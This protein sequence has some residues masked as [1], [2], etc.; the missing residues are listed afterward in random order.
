MT[1]PSKAR[2]RPLSVLAL[3]LALG[4]SAGCAAPA[5]RPEATVA[6]GSLTPIAAAQAALQ[7]SD[8][9]SAQTALAASLRDDLP[10]G[11]LQFLYALTYDQ[12][13]K[14]GSSAQLDMAQVG[15]ENAVRFT[16]QNYWARLMMGYLKLERGEFDAAQDHFAVAAL[17]QPQRWEAFY[18]LGVAS[19]HRGDLPMLQLAANRSLALAAEQ[20][21]AQRLAAFSL[22]MQGDDRARHLADNA[23]QKVS[24]VSGNSED[25]VF[26]RK[27]VDELLIGAQLRGQGQSQNLQI[28]IAP[29]PVGR[30]S[31]EFYTPDRKAAFTDN[32]TGNPD[33][34][35][36]MVVE[37]TIILN[38]QVDTKTR[39][40]NLFDGLRLQYGYAN[41][42]S[43]AS[44]TNDTDGFI[45]RVSESAR[46]IT[47]QISVPQINYNLNL[48]NDSKQYYGVIA[49]PSLTAYVGRES[50]FFAGRTISV[51]VS[52]IN[53]GELQPVDVGVKLK[54]AP[55]AISSE[56]T[57]FR[58][59]AAR[60]FLSREEIGR[61][62][63][64]LTT[65]KQFVQ[66]TAELSFGQT[67][68]LSALSEQVS[69]SNN[70]QV[71]LAGDVPGLNLFFRNRSEIKRQESLLILVTPSLPT[72]IQLPQDP[73][74]R[75]SNVQE[76]IRYWS[77]VVDP[78]SDVGAIV[79][80]LARIPSFRKAKRGDL[81]FR[82]S[83]SAALLKEAIDENLRLAQ[84]R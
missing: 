9:G 71:P 72:A 29:G 80:R 33:D 53:L 77:Q 21:D 42:F 6:D 62:Q 59:E 48:F 28:P 8:W 11:Y 36:Q 37:V 14:N 20:P 55:E 58:I 27:R 47:S 4:A 41:T 65:F 50:E 63:Q 23:V 51:A 76:L 73:A 54:L 66:A 84:A 39:G 17:D 78:G 44:N 26:L 10:N 32:A 2:T 70:S 75:L 34:P 69:D 52:G 22:A 43:Q 12:Q 13:A 64:S 83:G 82:P 16:P 15:Y 79:E 18:G 57:R 1:A 61:F 68:I 49:R 3:G 35:N 38:S 25:S 45:S 19:Y 67:L 40:V 46:A 24:T 5:T 7:K 30:P 60:S 81:P 74:R 31:A 56:A